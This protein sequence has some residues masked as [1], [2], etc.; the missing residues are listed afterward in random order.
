[1]EV[2]RARRLRRLREADRHGRLRAYYPE[3]AGLGEQCIKLHSKLMIVDDRLLRVGSANLNNRS[4]GVAFP[5]WRS[6]PSSI[7]TAST[8]TGAPS[9]SGTLGSAPSDDSPGGGAEGLGCS[10]A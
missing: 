4:F 1:M 8:G 2:L 9:A 10:G 6:S 7:S 3:Q 5:R